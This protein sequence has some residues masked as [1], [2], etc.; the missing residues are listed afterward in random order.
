ML[1]CLQQVD[2]LHILIG[3]NHSL[4]KLA[5]NYIGCS[6]LKHAHRAIERRGMHYL[7]IKAK[8]GIIAVL[9]GCIIPCE[10]ALRSPLGSKDH[11]LCISAKRDAQKAQ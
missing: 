2:K 11:L 8:L 1:Y 4:Y 3:R 10:L 6:I 5:S 9:K 7:H